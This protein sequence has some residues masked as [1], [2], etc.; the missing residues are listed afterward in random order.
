MTISL[1]QYLSP[2]K[3]AAY[4]KRDVLS[5]D[6]YKKLKRKFISKAKKSPEDADMWAL[7]VNFEKYEDND[8]NGFDFECDELDFSYTFIG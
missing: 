4:V 6:E 3:P 7:S 5:A 2:G 1:I 8:R